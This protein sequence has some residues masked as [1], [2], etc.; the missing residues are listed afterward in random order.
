M[1]TLLLRFPGR[2]YHATPWGHHVNEGL[3][4][5]PPSPWRVLRA[6]VSTGYTSLGWEGEVPPEDAR[7]LVLKLAGALPRYHLPSAAGAHSRHYMPLGVLD[8]GSEKTTLVFDTWAQVDGGQIA[9]T[10]DVDLTEVEA[11]LLGKLAEHLGY[12]GRSESWVQARLAGPDERVVEEINCWPCEGRLVPG[13]GWEQVSLLAP[14]SPVE[15]ASWRKSALD[16]VLAHLPVVD[17]AK[18]RLTQADKKALAQRKAAE[19]PFPGDII[20]CLQST[21]GWLRQHGWSLP[22]GSRQVI[23]ERRLDLLEAG[24]PRPR[25]APPAALR[26]EAMLLSLATPSGND[27]A[28]PVA[29]RTLPQAELLHRALVGVADKQLGSVPPVLSGCD[30]SGK[31]LT[32]GHAHAHIIPLDLDRDGHLEHILIWAPMG[33]DQRIQRV[34]RAVRETFTKG[35]VG[36][37]KLALIAAGT[38]DDL[39]LLPGQFGHSLTAVLGPPGGAT[40]WVSA[41]PFVPPRHRKLRGSN[42]LEGQVAAELA[43][44]GLSRPEDVRVLELREERWSTLRHF[45]RSRR[46]GPP[47]PVDCGFAVEIRLSKPE[48][49]PLCLGYGSHFGLGLFAALPDDTP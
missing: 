24:A 5:W 7:G 31:R 34:I 13:P 43:S 14:I 3:I 48:R 18:K 4:E 49:G 35:G 45:V 16:A 2:R 17:A 8:K 33:M 20:G 44:R 39:R 25:P 26:V 19:E 9:V 47:A 41:T 15:Y 1:A 28:L 22:P 21:T 10:W 23:Y 30:R 32:N 36:S 37:L 38:L 40:R 42:T 29:T 27:H 46:F 6:L 12:L 11:E